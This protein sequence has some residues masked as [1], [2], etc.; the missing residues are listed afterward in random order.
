MRA[1]QAIALGFPALGGACGRGLGPR[2]PVIDSRSL[3]LTHKYS[4]DVGLTSITLFSF[5]NSFY[6]LSK[7]G[8]MDSSSASA[9]KRPRTLE[10]KKSKL[11]H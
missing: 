7:G 3:G 5:C 9:S 6:V 11:Q 10:S 2:A 4:T 1:S 8:A